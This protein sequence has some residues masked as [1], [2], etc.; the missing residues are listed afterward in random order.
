[1]EN[2]NLVLDY[3]SFVSICNSPI[4][5]E[6]D[7]PLQFKS[8]VNFFYRNPNQSRVIGLDLDGQFYDRD[9]VSCFR[10]FSLVSLGAT[11][12]ISKY[13][14][15]INPY[16]NGNPDNYDAASS[17]EFESEKNL[18]SSTYATHVCILSNEIDVV[19]KCYEKIRTAFR[20]VTLINFT[21][22]FDPS[23]I[24]LQKAKELLQK[25]PYVVINEYCEELSQ[26]HSDL[27]DYNF[28]KK[29]DEIVTKVLEISQ[30]KCVLFG[31]KFGTTAEKMFKMIV[32]ECSIRKNP[33]FFYAED[34]MAVEIARKV[35][36][37]YLDHKNQ[38]IEDVVYFVDNFPL[39]CLE[40]K[41]S[42]SVL[43]RVI[44]K[45]LKLNLKYVPLY[46]IDKN[47][48]KVARFD[49]KA[50]NILSINSFY[51]LESDS[52]ESNLEQEKR[53]KELINQLYSVF[54]LKKEILDVTNLVFFDY[55]GITYVGYNQAYNI[56]L[57]CQ[58]YM[59]GLDIVERTITDFEDI[60]KFIYLNILLNK[61][62]L[63]MTINNLFAK[64]YGSSYRKIHPGQI[65]GLHRARNM[66]SVFKY[67][68]AFVN[69]DLK[70]FPNIIYLTSLVSQDS[71]T[72]R[73]SINKELMKIMGI[74]KLRESL[75]SFGSFN[76]VVNEYL[77][78]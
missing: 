64:K 24:L 75:N 16:E 71:S 12:G 42:Y 45:S 54:N 61:N 7:V 28:Y 70:M 29:F 47:E 30:N 11:S 43:N 22:K 27:L 68:H 74:E 51:N 38:L 19:E 32:I 46:A 48:V 44:G 23:K 5:V 53:L 56:E 58:S 63:L 20:N 50:I 17:F 72:Y 69:N 9:L 1:M 21:N 3:E 78:V 77:Y 6:V 55:D 8:I 65:K 62:P 60:D 34:E 76:K 14:V 4:D 59:P 13:I 2:E 49:Y 73:L 26:Y 33:F 35:S 67:T 37:C 41:G 39:L 18:P 52:Y 40:Y 57:K 10:G 15:F 66:A 31:G 36:S 25:T